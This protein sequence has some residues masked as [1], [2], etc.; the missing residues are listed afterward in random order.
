MIV[1]Q[2]TVVELIFV[3]IHQRIK[4]RGYSAGP[5]INY[6]AIVGSYISKIRSTRKASPHFR[7]KAG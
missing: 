1:K 4:R 2:V 6:P 5:I 7:M 3:D